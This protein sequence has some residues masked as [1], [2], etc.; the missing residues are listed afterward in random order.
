[1]GGQ[2]RPH[3][4]RDATDR[5]QGKN[6]S[7]R[8][9]GHLYQKDDRW[10]RPVVRPGQTRQAFPR[11]GQAARRQRWPDQAPGPGADA[12]G[13]DRD[14][15]RPGAGDRATHGRGG[16]QAQDPGAGAPRPQAGH[17]ARQLRVRDPL[18]LHVPLRAVRDRRHR[19]RRHRGVP[20]RVPERAVRQDG[21]QPVRAPERDLRVRDPEAVVPRQPL[22]ARRQAGIRRRRGW[23][24]PLPRPGRA[25]RSTRG[26]GPH[27]VTASGRSSG[28]PERGRC[29]ISSDCTGG[30][31]ARRS[32]AHRRPPSTSTRQQPTTPPTR[33]CGRSTLRC[34][35]PRR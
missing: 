26:P 4:E 11:P 1:M 21:A 31:S 3:P 25:R 24:D 34:T 8:G 27:D 19:G 6:R 18:P 29:A 23:R 5:M 10:V 17:D 2:H 7:R 15:V 12:R 35:S 33:L 9:T 22:Q 20:R 30:R 32:D 13:D 28:P 14:R 16:R